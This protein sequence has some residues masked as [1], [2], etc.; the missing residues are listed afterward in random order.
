MYYVYLHRKATDGE[1]FYVGKGKNLRASSYKSRS[2]FWKS[3]VAKYGYYIEIVETGLQEWY[4][5]ELEKDLISYYGRCDLGY[6]TLVN[7][8]DGGDGSSGY[9]MS[10][11]QI[12]SIK[13]R[14]L[15]NPSN[16][17]RNI[18]TFENFYT[19][20]VFK[21]TRR[22]FSIA[23]KFE[24]D[25]LF[26]SNKKPLFHGWFVNEITTRDIV[27]DHIAR[28]TKGNKFFNVDSTIRNFINLFNGDTYCGTRYDFESKFGLK[29]SPLVNGIVK[30]SHGW[31]TLELYNEYG[32]SLL[33][34]NKRINNG[35]ADQNDY[36][37]YNYW[38]GITFKGK[39]CDLEDTHG[40][41]VKELISGKC[42]YTKDG[43][44]LS[45]NK[46]LKPKYK[47]QFT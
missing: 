8:T 35:R 30:L 34:T 37:F 36:E 3:V 13:S 15:A 46:H 45:E 2:T 21:G 26:C 14:L 6:G 38:T 19:Y 27:E 12:E 7:L 44:C 24:P 20:E 25:I 39:R 16:V 22:D 31:T 28:T 18:Y 33:N 9:K 10:K 5:F 4:A 43:W 29:I 42:K 17:D 32:N 40:T 1:V 47:Q 11:E 41:S 23:H